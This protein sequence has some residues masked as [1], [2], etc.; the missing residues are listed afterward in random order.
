MAYLRN[1][2]FPGGPYLTRQDLRPDEQYRG[3]YPGMN[4]WKTSE[5]DGLSGWLDWLIGS[6]KWVD[7]GAGFVPYEQRQGGMFS[8][9]ARALQGG[10]KSASGKTTI[11]QGWL[12]KFFSAAGT[13][14]KWVWNTTSKQWQTVGKN[15]NPSWAGPPPGGVQP[16]TTTP[17]LTQTQIIPGFDNTTL[18]VMGAI[19]LVAFMALRSKGGSQQPIIVHGSK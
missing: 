7:P 16:P 19:A 10:T 5:L 15:E 3:M 13:V 8:W 1:A 4:R 17:Y 12:A 9:L 14:G 18:M 2:S 6:K 11:D